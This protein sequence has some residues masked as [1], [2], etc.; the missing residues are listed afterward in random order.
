M[1]R[2][3]QARIRFCDRVRCRRLPTSYGFC[4][5]LIAAFRRDALAGVLVILAGIGLARAEPMKSVAITFDDLPFAGAVGARLGN[6]SPVE[7]AARN[8]EVLATL[9]RHRAP[10]IGFVV[11]TA[12]QGVGRPATGIL[13]AWT[14]EGLSLGN[15]GYAHI[16]TNS[17]DLAGIRAEI[18][19]GE[20]TIRPLM[21]KAGQPLRFMRFAMNHTGD[22]P[23][24]RDGIAAL[25]AER[26]YEPAAS[27]IDSSDYIFEQAY[28]RALAAGAV[29]DAGKIR[30]AYLDHTDRQ[31]DYYAGLSRQVLGHEPPQVL[32]LHL[33]RLNAAALE[34]ILML[35]ERKGYRF[36]TLAEAQADPAYGQPV[37]FVTHFGPMW[38]YRW[39]R[40][41]GIAVDGKREVEPP[42]WVVDYQS[43][44]AK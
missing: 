2:W 5:E 35:F 28:G 22:T 4:R 16:D 10:A 32:L 13:E 8:S 30:A 42:Q 37:R 25:L 43:S 34:E 24:K 33:N 44:Q 21:A 15:H 38:A 40:D 20:T 3:L 9:R 27:T 17:L 6:I 29:G 39:A 18:E 12:V 11:E 23:E 14:R 41:R 26:G 7:V 19:Q 1:R 36:V 31:I